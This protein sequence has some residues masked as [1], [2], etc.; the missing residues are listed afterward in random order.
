MDLNTVRKCHVCSK[1][2]KIE[3]HKTGFGAGRRHY[4]SK[5]GILID[6]RNWICTKCHNY[7]MKEIDVEK[8]RT[9]IMKGD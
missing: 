8:I 9:K 3:L 5:E 1:K 7:M 2:I 6:Y 4:V